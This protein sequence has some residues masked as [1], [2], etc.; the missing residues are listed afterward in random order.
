M[1]L[2]RR[3]RATNSYSVAISTFEASN[4]VPP[5]STT[6]RFSSVVRCT[7]SGNFFVD[8]RKLHFLA[9]SNQACECHVLKTCYLGRISRLFPV[10]SYFLYNGPNETKRDETKCEKLTSSIPKRE[11]IVQRKSTYIRRWH[12]LPHVWFRR[13]VFDEADEANE[14]GNENERI[15]WT[16]NSTN[17][18]T[19]F[20]KEAPR[21][22]RELRLTPGLFFHSRAATK[23]STSVLW[24]QRSL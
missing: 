24:I 6:Q 21:L 1:E 20:Q 11:K 2:L 8:N 12:A 14:D 13:A 5:R 18:V 7:R 9:E 16:L 19:A 15:V 22:P 10:F 17:D 23:V 3:T 4:Q